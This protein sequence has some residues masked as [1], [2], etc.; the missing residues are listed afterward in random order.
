MDHTKN[1]VIFPDKYQVTDKFLSRIPADIWEEVFKCRLSPEVNSIDDLVACAKAIDIS[2]KMVAYYKKSI[3]SAPSSS[4]MVPQQAIVEP[5]TKPT[6][7]TCHPWYKNKMRE[8]KKDD[9]NHCHP[10][11]P[12]FGR[13]WDE[14]PH[15]FDKD[16]PNSRP[17]SQYE[18][19]AIED[20]HKP[21]QAMPNTC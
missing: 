12:P 21:P 19:K 9:N 18:P 16:K 2:K 10:P 17:K 13:T 14:A 8:V 4:R 5:A 3:S 15:I 11:H 20:R 7:Y 6:A 1:M